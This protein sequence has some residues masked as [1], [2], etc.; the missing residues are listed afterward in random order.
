MSTI[1]LTDDTEEDRKMSPSEVTMMEV[2]DVDAEPEVMVVAPPV[3]S[4]T[5]GEDADLALALSLQAGSQF[6]PK[7]KRGQAFSCGICLDD[8]I[9]SFKGYSVDGWLV[10]CLLVAIGIVFLLGL[11]LGL[12][13]V[14]PL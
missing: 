6:L 5:G 4:A 13:S 3:A 10:D 1:D 14:L 12:R 9:Q 7:R 2:V 11:T 8:D